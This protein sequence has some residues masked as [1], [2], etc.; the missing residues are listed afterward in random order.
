MTE[1]EYIK[2]TNRVKISAALALVRDCLASDV[3]ED[4]W[5]IAE[6]ELNAIVERLRAAEVKLFASYEVV[7]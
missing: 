2:A 6:K 1:N 4:D 3:I 7:G 5:G